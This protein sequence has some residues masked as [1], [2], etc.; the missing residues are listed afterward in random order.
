MKTRFFVLFFVLSLVLM[1]GAANAAPNGPA[2]ARPSFELALDGL[3]YFYADGTPPP[4]E[5]EIG[6]VDPEFPSVVIE[7]PVNPHWQGAFCGCWI[8]DSVPAGTV[9]IRMPGQ[10]PL[11]VSR[12]GW[13]V[14]GREFWAAGYGPR[15]KVFLPVISR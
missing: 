7:F 9:M 11:F 8:W 5:L 6:T 10:F 15:T 12:P 13:R 2:E 4:A 3:K 14:V 1:P